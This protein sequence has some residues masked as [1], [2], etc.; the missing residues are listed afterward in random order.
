[1]FAKRQPAFAGA[2]APSQ[3]SKFNPRA[4]LDRAKALAANPYVAAVGAGVLFL[5][6]ATTLVLVAGDPGAGAPAVTARV[7]RPQAVAAATPG[8]PV[9]GLEAF[10]I[11]SLGMGQDV[12][13]DG[14][15][16]GDAPPVQGTAV[17]VLPDGGMP[18]GSP[19][20][21][22]PA[23]RRA[24]SDPLPAAPLAGVV[25]PGP[26]GPMP[27]IAPDGRTPFSAYARPFKS[28]GRPK[29]AL[30]VGGLG[31]NPAATRNAI[32]RLPPEVTLSFV[33]YAE[34]LQG[35][36]DLAR[37]NGHEV[38]LEIPME[39]ADYPDNDPGPHTLLVQS[40]SADIGRR[41]DW[42]LS[43]AAGYVGVTNYLGDRFVGSEKGM[44]AFG[45]ILKSRGL[46]FIDD[47]SARSRGGAWARASASVI[48]DEQAT[49]EAI[50]GQ[51]NALEQAAKTRG[52]AL[53]T[54]FAYPVTVE[55]AV[56]W[57]QG[58]KARG[59]QLAPASAVAKR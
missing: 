51:F 3:G 4:L 36:I 41:M 29:V 46:A 26:L 59:L 16:L 44:A 38:L 23:T 33:P 25:Q 39:P 52:A 20:S 8:Q 1:M 43:R 2:Q 47:G 17:I 6:A 42:L 31:L 19:S 12:A 34:G 15:D 55:V 10:T 9:N 27:V 11:D 13:V 7:Q 32:E 5:G 18:G 58:V 53:G 45:A 49:A 37:A 35:W 50:V 40:D 56:R 24:P 22:M 48:L 30:I 57:A 21:S 14:F 54:G 28:D